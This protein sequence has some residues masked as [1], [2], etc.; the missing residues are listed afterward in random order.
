VY[1]SIDGAAGAWSADVVT[2]GRVP[3]PDCGGS[4]ENAPKHEE[5]LAVVPG[6]LTHHSAHGG[7]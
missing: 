1:A 6:T 3:V 5:L 2:V 4:L 7:E